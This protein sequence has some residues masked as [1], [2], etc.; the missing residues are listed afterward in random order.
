M[1]IVHSENHGLH[2]PKYQLFADGLRAAV[3]VPDRVENILAVLRNRGVG[4]V[5]GPGPYG[6]AELRTVH[7]EGML[8][9]LAAVHV[10]WET[11][12]M[13]T[14]IGLIPDTFAMR[15]L[16]SKPEGW[17]E[18]VGYY[19]FETQTP[20][21]PR[22]WEAAKHA[23]CC[24]LTGA[25][26]LLSGEPSAYALCRPPGHHAGRDLYG[27]YCYLNNAALAARRLS[28]KGRVAILDVDYHHGNGTQAIFYDSDEV[29]YASL[30]AD[31]NF[32]YPFFSG[33]KFENGE[34]RGG[35]YTANFPLPEGCGEKA[36]FEALHR[37]VDCATAFGA[38]FWV[39][40]LGVDFVREDP[41]SRF[42]ISP[43]VCTEVGNYLASEKKPTLFVQEGGY[44]L[45]GIG[46]CVADVL[47]GFMGLAD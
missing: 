5:V 4:E 16:N 1:K 15:S 10:A 41:M 20:I 28:S 31:P 11:A 39:I 7:D 30:H 25:D 37:A 6:W 12:G 36:F 43:D 46:D 3:E 32:E 29:F 45:E 22:T 35:G 9:F 21:L 18:Q 23:A 26:L 8:R 17:V 19:C 47:E 24:A 33:H 2:A 27:G 44:W 34:G 38:D 42:N 13:A 40:S 14:E